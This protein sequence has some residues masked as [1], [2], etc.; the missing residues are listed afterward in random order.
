ML[1]NYSDDPEVILY[2]SAKKYALNINKQWVCD[3][4]FISGDQ[5]IAVVV[6]IQLK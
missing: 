1:K 2:H 6:Q 5:F 3:G 4:K